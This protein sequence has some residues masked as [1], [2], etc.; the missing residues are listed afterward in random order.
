MT[1][2]QLVGKLHLWLGLTSGL[3][4]F[5]VSLTGA[6]FVFQDDIRDLTEPWRKV[7]AQAT[8][9]AL[10]SQLQAAALASHSW[11]DI[12]LGSDTGGSTR[13]P[14]AV[15]GLYG[16]RPSFGAM[17]LDGVIPLFEK[18]DTLTYVRPSQAAQ[19]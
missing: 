17:P 9:M 5:I 14:A 10:P 1:A 18:R 11:L 12:A 13:V 15:M 16:I 3:V 4:V 8:A 7:E 2:K 6:I 19:I